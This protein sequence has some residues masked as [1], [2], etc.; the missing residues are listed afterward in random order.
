[1]AA[2]LRVPVR[3]QPALVPEPRSDS[4]VS[5]PDEPRAVQAPALAQALVRVAAQPRV[6]ALAPLPVPVV[7]PARDRRHR[8]PTAAR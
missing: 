7:A 5:V 4:E 3:L 1:M 2:E 8:R 6:Q